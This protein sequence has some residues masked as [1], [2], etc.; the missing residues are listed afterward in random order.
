MRVQEPVVL[1]PP[2]RAGYCK[3]GM[4]WKPD[5][6]TP[7]VK[8]SCVCSSDL[9]PGFGSLLILVTSACPWKQRSA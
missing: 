2:L 9:G 1:T 7:G 6:W 4:F 8:D 3:S 5:M